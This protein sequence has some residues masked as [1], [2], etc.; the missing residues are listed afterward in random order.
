LTKVYETSVDL[1]SVIT[2]A[3]EAGA[4]K[5]EPEKRLIINVILRAISDARSLRYQQAYMPKYALRQKKNAVSWLLSYSTRERTLLWYLALLSDYPK[6]KHQ[7]ILS[8]LK[9]EGD[10]D[11]NN[12]KGIYTTKQRLPEIS[13]YDLLKI[14][15]KTN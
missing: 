5:F 1:Y 12:K 8:Y 10:V 6:Q 4:L 13:K 9:R 15:I 14:L 3:E 2:E 11:S 7:A